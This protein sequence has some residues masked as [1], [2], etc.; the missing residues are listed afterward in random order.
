[1]I[2][3]IFRKI[4]PRREKSVGAYQMISSR[5]L[6]DAV[7]KWKSERNG[8]NY[9]M[10]TD[11]TLFLT[12]DMINSY[13]EKKYSDK[14]KKIIVIVLARYDLVEVRSIIR[15]H[16]DYWDAL[17]GEQLDFFWLGYSVWGRPNSPGCNTAFDDWFSPVF[18]DNRTF[19]K[20]VARLEKLTD[21]DFGDEIGL[22]LFE[23]FNGIVRY[24]RS[25]YLNIEALAHQEVDT[26]LKRFFRAL[27]R[28]CSVNSRITEVKN[29]LMTKRFLYSLKDITIIDLLNVVEPAKGVIGAFKVS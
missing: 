19:I 26:K 24:D 16:Y 18:F 2:N 6:L 23:T 9:E 4:G 8:E 11:N 5:T 25:L 21:Y 1:M 29:E 13:C 22:L 28:S 27:I 10:I 12:L 14:T 3:R 7:R 17:T 20:D 15:Q